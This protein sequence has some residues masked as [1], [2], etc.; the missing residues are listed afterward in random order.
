MGI[1]HRRNIT[2]KRTTYIGKE[3]NKIEEQPLIIEY[4]SKYHNTEENL[5][6]ILK[7]TPREAKDIGVSRQ[8]L[9]KIKKKIRERKK[10]NKK[11]KAVKKLFVS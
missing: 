11:T 8:T 9:H 4:P 6:N 10:I 3:V 7:M 2:L 5:Q 1:L